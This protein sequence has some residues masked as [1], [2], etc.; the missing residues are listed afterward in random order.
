VVSQQNPQLCKAVALLTASHTNNIASLYLS[1]L[2]GWSQLPTLLA[3]NSERLTESY[4]L[5][6][7]ALDQWK[8]DFVAP[9]HGIFLFAKLGMGIKSVVEEKAFYNRLA[10][11]GVRVSPGRFYNGPEFEYGWARI[12]FSVSPDTMQIALERIVSFLLKESA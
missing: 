1:S 9:S 5:L 6:A 2:L 4:S 3:L 7:E 10:V 12:R 11:Q 8:I